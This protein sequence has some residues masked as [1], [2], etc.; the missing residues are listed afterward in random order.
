[1]PGPA[2]GE[3][4]TRPPC[5]SMI[6]RQAQAI[7]LGRVECV[8]KSVLLSLFNRSATAAQTYLSGNYRRKGGAFASAPSA[9]S[10]LPVFD[11]RNDP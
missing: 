2:L 4:H 7:M 5:A 8:E 11:A 1:M 6:E 10:A 9:S 3:P